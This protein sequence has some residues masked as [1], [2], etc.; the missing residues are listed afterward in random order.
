VIPQPGLAF[1]FL[2]MA[3]LL[4]LLFAMPP[5]DAPPAITPNY[6]PGSPTAPPVVTPA[7]PPAAAH[8]AGTVTFNSVPADGD[9]ITIGAV[10]YRWQ[11]VIN[12]SYDIEV[13]T[14]VGEDPPTVGQAAL[15]L[16]VALGNISLY[17]PA[18]HPTVEVAGVAG[19][20]VSL[21]AKEAGTGGN[22]IGL[23]ETGTSM[24]VSG[25]NLTGG[26]AGTNTSAPPAAS[27]SYTPATPSPPPAI[28]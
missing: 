21:R 8:A 16:A 27:A 10:T 14:G 1:A 5:P 15:A 17:I 13:P 20:T 28:S 24:T 2:A 4:F 19:A 6:T 26:V 7:T 25:A 3:G 18:V 22:A 23:S 12:A 11:D 9:T